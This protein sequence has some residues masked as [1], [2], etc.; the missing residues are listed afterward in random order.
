MDNIERKQIWRM[1]DRIAPRYDLLN[2]LLSAGQDVRWR[3]R[4]ATHLAPNLEALLDIAT[5][6]GDQ[7]LFLHDKG[8][9]IESGIGVDMSAEMLRLGVEKIKKRNLQQRF[10]LRQADALNLPFEGETFEAVTIS[11]GIRNVT[12]IKKSFAEVLRVLKPAGT[13]LVLEFSLP[14]NLLLRYLYLFY[15]RNILPALGSAISGDRE[16]YRYLNKTVESF[17]YGDKFADLLREAGFSQVSYESLTFG[18]STI[19]KAVK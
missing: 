3:K 12:D 8:I 9:Q 17:P 10:I 5:G 11:F 19:Y 4:M 18:I 2:R 15:F 7:L 6:T 16:A 13:F 1:F 14:R